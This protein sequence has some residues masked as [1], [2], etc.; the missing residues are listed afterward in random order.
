M[1]L[2]KLKEY[3]LE[4]K[5]LKKVTAALNATGL[6]GSIAVVGKKGEILLSEFCTA[7]DA[8]A[9]DVLKSGNHKGEA[10]YVYY[11]AVPQEFFDDDA[12]NGVK[13]DQKRPIDTPKVS[14]PPVE[15][16]PK[17]EVPEEVEPEPEDEPINPKVTSDCPTFR[18]G[19]DPKEEDCVACAL[20]FPEEHDT[21][22]LEVERAAAKPKKKGKKKAG[23]KKADG[24]P[25]P[26]PAGKRTRYGHMPTSMAGHIDDMVY[27]G[28]TK[29]Q[30]VDH[31]VA[32]FERTKEKAN[33]KASS[34]LLTLGGKKGITITDIGDGVLKATEE[35]TA[36]QDASNTVPSS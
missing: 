11:E 9:D 23:K 24:T 33:A 4:F 7:V 28:K 15:T 13:A 27:E 21:C 16:E 26:R 29:G 35:Y 3:G 36:G 2:Q 17:G 22:K 6:V 19:W 12:D 25:A 30:M 31:L 10:W 8:I 34:H 20:D 5:E 18:T 32:N 1:A 14:D